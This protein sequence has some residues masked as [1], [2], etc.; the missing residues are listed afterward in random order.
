MIIE[1][2]Y[3]YACALIA[4]MIAILKENAEIAIKTMLKEVAMDTEVSGHK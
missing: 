4:Y 3:V 1:C 2:M